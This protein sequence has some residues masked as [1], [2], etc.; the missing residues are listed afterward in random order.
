MTF[1]PLALAPSQANATILEGRGCKNLNGGYLKRS[2][3]RVLL[4]EDFKPYRDFVTSLLDENPSFRVIC[5]ASDG[6]EAVEKARQ[7]SPDVILM[8]I[9]LPKLNGLKAAQRIRQLVPTSKIVFLS[10]E[11]SAEFVQE[12][13]SLDAPG[14]VHKL[15]AQSDL[16]PA[17]EAVLDGK[18]FV[19]HGLEFDENSQEKKLTSLKHA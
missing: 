1:E 7:M 4:V 2:T 11:S 14:F 18:R 10:Q 5:E 17:I 15:R 9:A 16:L 8:D 6:L 3:I 13:M 19:G 12:A